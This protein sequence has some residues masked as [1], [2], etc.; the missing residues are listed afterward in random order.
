MGVQKPWKPQVWRVHLT[1]TVVAPGVRL[2]KA[3]ERYGTSSMVV[4]WP[5]EALP[6]D[7]RRFA[8]RTQM[9]WQIQLVRLRSVT[10]LPYGPPDRAD[11]KA[12]ATASAR[13]D[14]V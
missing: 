12:R 13:P 6:V 2:K 1:R 11:F 9:V 4:S 10:H 5:I 3:S 7:G 8:K 14:F